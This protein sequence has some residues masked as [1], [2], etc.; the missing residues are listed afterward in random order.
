M[1]SQ[2]YYF[3]NK[4]AY[5]N[6][7]DY[8]GNPRWLDLLEKGE[9]GGY[10]TIEKP[11]FDEANA[12][13]IESICIK[14]G[15]TRRYGDYV[16]EY[17][18][19]IKQDKKNFVDKESIARFIKKYIDN[20]VEAR[21]KKENWYSGEATITERTENNLKVFEYSAREPYLD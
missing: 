12:L 6:N 2:L 19:I 18:L 11:E 10:K 15:Q 21:L 3:V 8:S 20:Q 4:K 14:Q 9:F 16:Y 1:E 17:K 5:L 7:T 13:I